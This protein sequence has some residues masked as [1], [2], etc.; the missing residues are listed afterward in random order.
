MFSDTDINVKEPS[1]VRRFFFVYIRIV[2]RMLESRYCKQYSSCNEG[3]EI[4]CHIFI[5]EPVC[6]LGGSFEAYLAIEYIGSEK[7]IDGQNGKQRTQ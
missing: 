2:C 5:P 4:P 7:H 3:D 6:S 1:L